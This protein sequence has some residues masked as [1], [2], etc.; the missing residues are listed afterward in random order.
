[1]CNISAK[2]LSCFSLGKLYNV[3]IYLDIYVTA[4]TVLLCL[5]TSRYNISSALATSHSRFAIYD[6]PSLF[7]NTSVSV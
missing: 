5:T 2:L 7:D 1:M 6:I 3:A 4:N